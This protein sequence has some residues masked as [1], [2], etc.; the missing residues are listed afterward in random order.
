MYLCKEDRNINLLIIIQMTNICFNNHLQT[1]H[2]GGVILNTVGHFI[3][4]HNVFH[5]PCLS[6]AYKRQ[7]LYL[8]R[9]NSFNLRLFHTRIHNGRLK[10]GAFVQFL[11]IYRRRC[12][13][14]FHAHMAISL[15]I[16]CTGNDTPNN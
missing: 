1:V 12:Y 11:V 4:F 14:L 6:M 9:L 5:C 13:F 15:N 7:T 3:R 8:I 10:S 2:Y 16:I